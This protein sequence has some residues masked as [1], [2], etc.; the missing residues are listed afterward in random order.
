MARLFGLLRHGFESLQHVS[1]ERS[2]MTR[3][4]GRGYQ[5]LIVAKDSTVSQYN[6]TSRFDMT[7]GSDCHLIRPHKDII[8]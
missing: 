8:C 7:H 6:L 1:R 3:G 2:S 5:M 4:S